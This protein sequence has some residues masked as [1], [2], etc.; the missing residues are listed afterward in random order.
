MENQDKHN[1]K[2]LENEKIEG[3]NVLGGAGANDIDHHDLPNAGLGGGMDELGPIAEV[4]PL[5]TP[6]PNEDGIRSLTEAP[7]VITVPG[8]DTIT[9]YTN[10]NT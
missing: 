7:P 1:L 3:T 9:G 10:G 8:I 4:I 6:L 2:N 5:E